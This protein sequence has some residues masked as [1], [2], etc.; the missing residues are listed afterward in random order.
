MDKKKC[1]ATYHRYYSLDP[2]GVEDTGEIVVVSICANCGDPIE[3][4]TKVSVAVKQTPSI[5]E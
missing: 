2:I 3:Y 1:E 4:R 5:S